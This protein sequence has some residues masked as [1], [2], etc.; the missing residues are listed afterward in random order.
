MKEKRSY[1]RGK[2]RAQSCTS[3]KPLVKDDGMCVVTTA[4]VTDGR[5]VGF[6][7]RE[8]PAHPN[9]TGWRFGTGEES[10]EYMANPENRALCHLNCLANRDPEIIPFLD[11]PSESAFERNPHTGKFEPVE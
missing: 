10:D 5:K 2:K 9:D 4:I 11:A 3:C 8:E 6:M 7:Y 1:K